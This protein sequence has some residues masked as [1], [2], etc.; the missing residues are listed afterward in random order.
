MTPRS[1]AIRRFHQDDL[2]KTEASVRRGKGKPYSIV[3]A[4][5]RRLAS[6]RLAVENQVESTARRRPVEAV[7]EGYLP[8]QQRL[9]VRMTKTFL[10][11]GCGS[12][13]KNATTPAF[14]GTHWQ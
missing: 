8:N 6:F 1:P 10:H 14:A 3:S 13:R 5:I 2:L 11:V 4:M 12:A 7:N 9:E